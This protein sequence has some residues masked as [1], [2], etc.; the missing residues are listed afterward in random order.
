MTAPAMTSPR[1]SPREL[2]AL[3]QGPESLRQH[4]LVAGTGISAVGAGKGNAYPAEN[5]DPSN[6]RAYEHGI[7]LVAPRMPRRFEIGTKPGQDAALTR[8]T[9]SPL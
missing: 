3:D 4:V 9:G 7:S 1:R 5:C 2:E 6:L 8:P